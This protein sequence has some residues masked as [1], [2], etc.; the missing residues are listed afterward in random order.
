MKRV[1]VHGLGQTSDSWEKV[2][3]QLA[4]LECSVC[5]NLA[6]LVK[7]KDVTYQN[8]YSAFS[9]MCNAIEEPISLYGLSLGGVLALNYAIEHPTKVDA[10]ALIAAQYEE[11][12]INIYT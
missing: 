2:V 8:L 11:T 3:A 10:L 9:A 5:P 4:P 1:Y 7:G 12:L 6:E